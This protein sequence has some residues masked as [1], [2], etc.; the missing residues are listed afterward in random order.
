MSNV[1]HFFFNLYSVVPLSTCLFSSTG[2]VP[3][4]HGQDKESRMT[5]YVVVTLM[6]SCYGAILE[7]GAKGDV[8]AVR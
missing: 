8:V 1:Y 7:V 2:I 4:G 5:E 6:V 3:S